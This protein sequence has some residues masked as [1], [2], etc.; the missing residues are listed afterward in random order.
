[1]KS[2]RFQLSIEHLWGLI[3][4]VGIFVFIN[5]HPIRPHDFWWHITI[6]RE[7]LETG[8]IPLTDI[9]SYTAYGQPYPSYQMFWLME[10]F[11]YT[12]YKFGGPALVILVHSVLISCAYVVIFLLCKQISKSWR[13][14][15]FGVFFAAAFGLNDWNVRPQGITFLIASLYLMAIYKYKQKLNRLW[16]FIFPLGMLVWVNSHG[17][18]LIGLVL[19]GIWL[20]Q[21][22]WE[23]VLARYRGEAEPK[24]SSTYV[25]A[26]LLGITT[27]ACL[28][29][30]RGLGIISYIKTLTSNSVIQ[31]L[32]TEWAPPSFNS[33]LGMIFFIGL[34]LSLIILVLS[35]R[36]LSLYQILTLLVFG[37]LGVKTSRGSVWF[38]IAM[39][40]I[41]AQQLPTLLERIRK[42]KQD[43]SRSQGSPLINTI[44]LLLIICMGVFSLPW[45]KDYWPLPQ[46]KAGLISAETPVQATNV[47]LDKRLPGHVFHAMSFGSYLIWAAYP[48]YQVFVDPR[49]ELYPENVW[50]DYLKISNASEDWEAILN[51]YG[52]NTL[53]LS[54]VEQ[55]NLIQSAR[56]TGAW[57]EQYQDSAAVLFTRK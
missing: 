37:V 6:G 34:L 43:I 38:G 17:T 20:A 44:F 46:A 41:L 50:M 39:A 55:A 52:V 15:A 53:M 9:Y 14:A 56:E 45:F 54:P 19:L 16:L 49:I 48:E 32:V 33:L 31:N 26:S 23:A 2:T 8:K 36:Q 10:L 35:A 47:L 42:P 5:T 22:I 1:M 12:I 11:L 27:L 30:P 57:I 29:N 28:A 7:I 21:E 4:L 13:V 24:I 3:V 25:P 18:F 51:S 40:P